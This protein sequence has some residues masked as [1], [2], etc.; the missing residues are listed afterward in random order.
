[1]P[2]K[3]QPAKKKVTKGPNEKPSTPK[4]KTKMDLLKE[5]YASNLEGME[6]GDLLLTASCALFS[7]E[8]EIVAHVNLEIPFDT[9]LLEDGIPEAEETFRSTFKNMIYKPLD[10]KLKNLIHAKLDA[11]Q[12]AKQPKPPAL[13]QPVQVEQP[14]VEDDSLEEEESLEGESNT[15]TDFNS[16]D[17]L[18][19][20]MM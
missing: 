20:A 4:P 9:I 14:V 2:E 3:K 15:I 12:K 16:G 5:K 18:E 11:Y 13:P 19:K 17:Q 7:D 1:M 10:R 8:G 6:E